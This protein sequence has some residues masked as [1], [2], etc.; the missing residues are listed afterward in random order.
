[1]LHPHVLISIRICLCAYMYVHVYIHTDIL[2]LYMY[3]YILYIQYYTCTCTLYIHLARVLYIIPT[4]H[5]LPVGKNN[6]IPYC[7]QHGVVQCTPTTTR[8]LSWYSSCVNRTGT[9]TQAKH[10]PV[11]WAMYNGS[12]GSRHLNKL[13]LPRILV[14]THIPNIACTRIHVGTYILVCTCNM[15]SYEYMYNVHVLIRP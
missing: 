11:L 4:A 10:G 14:R 15:A 3:T 1:M 13:Q 8:N 6:T 7:C 12:H 2:L 9:H 5:T